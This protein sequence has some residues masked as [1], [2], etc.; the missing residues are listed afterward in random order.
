MA[1]VRDV[2]NFKGREVYSIAPDASVL[3]ALKLMAEK[4]VGALVVLDGERLEGILSERDFARAVA[5]HG[6]CTLEAPVSEYMTE[7]V[8]TISPDHLMGDCLG[9]MTVKHF[10]HLPVLENGKLVGLISIG[11]VVREVLSEKDSTIISLENY[12]TGTGYGR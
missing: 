8:V 10:R 6:R 11:D 2:L 7:E 4:N 3:D 5:D 9:L 12:I 1:T